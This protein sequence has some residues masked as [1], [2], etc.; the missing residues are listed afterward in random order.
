LSENGFCELKFK[1]QQRDTTTLRPYGELNLE[2]GA[3]RISGSI[4]EAEIDLTHPI[5]FGLN[6]DRIP[7][8][9]NSTLIAESV[10]RPFAVPVRYTEDPLLS[11]YVQEDFYDSLRSAPA[12]MVSGHGSGRIISFMDNPNFRGFWYGTNRLF[13]NAIFFGPVISQASTR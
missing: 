10:Y 2:R 6:R 3:Q 5:G 11:G 4:F 8:F 1:E 9:R 12:V 13:M 7:L